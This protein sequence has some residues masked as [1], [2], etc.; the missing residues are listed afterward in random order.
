MTITFNKTALLIAAAMTAASMGASLPEPAGGA[1]TQPIILAITSRPT[2][3]SADLAPSSQLTRDQALSVASAMSKVNGKDIVVGTVAPTGSMRP[4]FDENALL[5]LEAA[6]FGELR[7]GDVVT[8]Y[9]PRLHVEVVHR[10]LEKRG[11]AF[12]SKGDHNNWMDDVLVTS[13]NYHRRLVGVIYFQSG[14]AQPSD[15]ALTAAVR[16]PPT[17]PLRPHR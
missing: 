5:L 15:A 7:L 14:T 4:Y 3:H 10:L 17:M 12:W 11:D 16:N 8:F 2:H 13:E 6:P 1:A 9:H